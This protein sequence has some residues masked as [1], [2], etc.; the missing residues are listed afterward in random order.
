MPHSSIHSRNYCGA[1]SLLILLLL[2]DLEQQR[3]VDVR[4]D[5]TKSNGSANEGV[6]FFV[7][8]DGE[9]KVAWGDA[10]DFEILGRVAG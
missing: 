9:L 5:A 3:T 7:A 10:L 6:Q 2:L 1:L 8:A 4:Q